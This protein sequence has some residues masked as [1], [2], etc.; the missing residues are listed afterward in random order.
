MK[1]RAALILGMILVLTPSANSQKNSSL[2]VSFPG[3]EWAI[4]IPTSGFKIETDKV[5]TDGR[6]Y[7]LATNETNGVTIS[8][9][10]ERG[11]QPATSQ[12]CHDSASRRPKQAAA[13]KIA[14]IAVHDVGPF[15]VAEY[16]VVQVGGINLNQRNIFACLA[17]EDIYADVH[18]S[19]VSFRPSEESLLMAYVEG[20]RVLD[21]TSGVSSSGPTS[22]DYFKE[23]SVHY[24]KGDFKGAIEPYQKALDLEKLNPT[25]GQTLWRVLLDNL[26]IAYGITGDLKNS[27]DV[28]MYGISEDPTYP[29]FYYNMACVYAESKDLDN[30]MAS[31]K[32]AFQYKQN[33]I[34]GETMPNPRTD[35][36]FQSFMHTKQFLDL[37]DSLEH[38]PTQ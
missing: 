23:G 7:V 10:M 32:K 38:P 6:K 31:L 15:S 27:R 8:V 9:M 18:I 35:D 24:E 1:A 21:K 19:K 11:S 25:L 34:P 29:L 17:R 33:M 26:A 22:L 5:Q 14:D 16:T 37:L 4:Q 3:K 20:A 36:S 12:E 30:T 13:D 2:N 28:I